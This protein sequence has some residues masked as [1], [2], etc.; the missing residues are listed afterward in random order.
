MLQSITNKLR[1]FFFLSLSLLLW[2]L[3]IA[4]FRIR[5]GTHKGG[6]KPTES[7]YLRSIFSLQPSKHHVL[8]VWLL[9]SGPDQVNATYDQRGQ[10]INNNSKD[11]FYQPHRSLCFDSPND[12]FDVIGEGQPPSLAMVMKHEIV[13]K[14]IRRALFTTF[15]GVVS[16]KAIEYVW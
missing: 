13:Y 7:A 2:R 15:I 11:C 4:F 9:P 12:P 5:S 3:V 14:A 16:R 1:Y 8:H 10:R 6:Y